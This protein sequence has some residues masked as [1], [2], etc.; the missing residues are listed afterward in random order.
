VECSGWAGPD[1]SDEVF[2][3]SSGCLAAPGPSESAATL[4]SSSIGQSLHGFEVAP[5][6]SVNA[7]AA[8]VPR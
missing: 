4:L 2:E 1:G 3:Q 7:N 6:I 5:P 8:T